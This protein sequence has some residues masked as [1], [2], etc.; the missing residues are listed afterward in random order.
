M[1][2][3]FNK[4]AVQILLA[5]CVISGCGWVEERDEYERID[6]GKPLSVPNDLDKPNQNT[7]LR[8]PEATASGRAPDDKPIDLLSDD[9]LR[10][11]DS[12]DSRN[13]SWQGGLPVLSIRS[14]I[15]ESFSKVSEALRTLDFSIEDEDADSQTIVFE[16]IDSHARQN[17]PGVFS[18]WILRRKGPEDQSG[19]YQLSLLEESGFSRVSLLDESGQPASA[20]IAERILLEVDRSIN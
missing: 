2:I 8:I 1:K 6:D 11:R 5:I 12:T 9:Q 17:R 18:R 14:S 19:Y 7:Q 20:G 16:Y 10:D 3:P 15:D 13:I 4:H